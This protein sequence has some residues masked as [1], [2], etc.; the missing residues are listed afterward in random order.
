MNALAPFPNTLSTLATR[1]SL[2]RDKRNGEADQVSLKKFK[3]EHSAHNYRQFFAARWKDFVRENFATPAHVA[4]CF[5]VTPVTAQNWWDGLNA[6]QG[7][8]VARAMTDPDLA[9]NASRHL[10]CETF[11]AE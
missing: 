5:N 9:E 4:V 7:W 10:T 11:A 6:P 1:F 2:G 8:V 3:K